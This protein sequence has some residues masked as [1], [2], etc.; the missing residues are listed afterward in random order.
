[1]NYSNM[2]QVNSDNTNDEVI[3]NNDNILLLSKNVLEFEGYEFNNEILV[4][5]ESKSTISITNNSTNKLKI[6]ITAKEGCTKYLIRTE[7]K[8]VTVNKGET[9][10]FEVF[11]KPLC[12]FS[13]NKDK[14]SIV[15]SSGSEKGQYELL[16]KFKTEITTKLDPDEL[17]EEERLGEG[18]F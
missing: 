1:M 16:M 12:I 18:G 11:I 10:E 14:L 5:K 15:Y 3:N 8:K 6:K 2:I 13:S 17:C 4:N 7:P 9:V